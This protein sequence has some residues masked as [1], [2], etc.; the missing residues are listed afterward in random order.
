[1]AAMNSAEIQPSTLSP[2]GPSTRTRYQSFDGATPTEI[3]ISPFGKVSIRSDSELGPE[4][5]LASSIMT[6]NSP[7][8]GVIA[9]GAGGL[10]AAARH[11]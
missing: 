9:N 11:T 4:R 8:T 1:M 10:Q 3:T 6:L 7:A 2:S 5:S